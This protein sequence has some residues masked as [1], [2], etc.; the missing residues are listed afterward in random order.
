MKAIKHFKKY[1]GA[2][3]ALIIIFAVSGCERQNSDAADTKRSEEFERKWKLKEATVENCKKSI[4]SN[5]NPAQV[6]DWQ[7]YLAPKNDT[8]PAASV[9]E[10]STGFKYAVEATLSGHTEKIKY[11]CYTGNDAQ[12]LDLQSDTGALWKY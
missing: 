11:Y 3:A 9:T 12:V 10:T 8:N 7:G 6:L 2:L 5:A 1:T 4:Q